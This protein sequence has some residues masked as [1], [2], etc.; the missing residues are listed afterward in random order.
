MSKTPCALCEIKGVRVRHRNRLARKKLPVPAW[1][2]REARLSCFLTI[3]GCA[4]LL[5]VS[6]RTVQ[7]WETGKARIPYAAFKLMRVLRGGKLLGPEWHGFIVRQD[8]LITPEGHSVEASDLGWWTLL[9][10][11]AREFGNARRQLREV[12]DA[13]SAAAAA[14]RADRP[15]SKVAA[16]AAPCDPAPA[17][18]VPPIG[19]AA[20]LDHQRGP[21]VG[22]KSRKAV[23]ESRFSE[24]PTSNRGVSETERDGPSQ[25]KPLKT[26]RIATLPQAGVAVRPARTGLARKS[27]GSRKA[28]QAVQS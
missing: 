9:V 23:T 20:R 8:K 2:F 14:V 5:R 27:V 26:R 4:D 28:A 22:S 3:Q 15:A 19:R 25:A 21:L 16:G 13:S 6:V 12:Q 1:R 11:R 18:D 7:N 17:P 24:L 10:R